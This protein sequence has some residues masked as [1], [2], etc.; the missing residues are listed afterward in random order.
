MEFCRECWS[1]GAGDGLEGHGEDL[2][3]PDGLVAP[4][5]GSGCSGGRADSS[6]V[7]LRGPDGLDDR[8]AGIPRSRVRRGSSWA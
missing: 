5:G 7:D 8:C 3:R 2:R 1:S 6:G 4:Q